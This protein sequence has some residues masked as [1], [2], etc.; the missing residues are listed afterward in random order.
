M[1]AHPINKR[2]LKLTTKDFRDNVV[3]KCIKSPNNCYLNYNCFVNE[4]IKNKFKKDY[5]N[6]QVLRTK[7]IQ[8]EVI[9]LIVNEKYFFRE[10]NLPIF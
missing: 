5:P 1:K 9:Y 6:H 7:N 10:T 8:G 3:Y 4:E 2:K